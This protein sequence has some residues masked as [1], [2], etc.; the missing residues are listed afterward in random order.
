MFTES[1]EEARPSGQQREHERKMQKAHILVLITY[2]KG[3]RRPFVAA[4]RV[5]SPPGVEGVLFSSPDNRQMLFSPTV[6]GA[7][8]SSLVE[9][10]HDKGKKSLHDEG[11]SDVQDRYFILIKEEDIDLGSQNHRL[12]EIIKDKEVDIHGLSLELERDKWIINFLEQ[13]SK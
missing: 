4:K 10:V 7:F 8:P 11:L 1:E 3:T 13:E 9:K 6:K 2:E 5:L 12:K